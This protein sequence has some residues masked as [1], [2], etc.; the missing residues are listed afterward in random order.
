[1]IFFILD[2]L[3]IT[4]PILD[5]TRPYKILV[6]WSSR[7]GIFFS[8]PDDSRTNFVG[9]VTVTNSMRGRYRGI[10][11]AVKEV[12]ATAVATSSHFHMNWCG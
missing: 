12:L 7:N 4:Y 6:V 9:D 5:G 10:G 3:N 8:L 1:M 11:T 2:V